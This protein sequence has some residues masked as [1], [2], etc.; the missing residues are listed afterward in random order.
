MTEFNKS[1]QMNANKRKYMSPI[2]KS[3]INNVSE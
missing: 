1:P 2:I 3:I